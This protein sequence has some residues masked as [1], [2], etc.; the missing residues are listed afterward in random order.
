VRL[1]GPILAALVLLAAC[2]GDR[3]GGPTGDPTAVVQASPDRTVAAGRA[4][5]VVATRAAVGTGTIDFATGKASL[6]VKPAAQTLAEFSDPAVAIEV[7][8]AA[9][10]IV[11]YGGAEVRGASTIKYE[12]DI[13]PSPDLLARLGRP[14]KGDT[15]YAD[16]SIDAQR[17]IRQVAY[18]LDLNEKRPSDTH[19][20]L[21]KLVTVDFYDF[22]TTPKA[23]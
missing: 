17:R 8:R 4:H 1:S 2:G 18:P 7:V 9:V 3:T 15:F 22:P 5:V 10:S 11:P 20:I 23:G 14:L 13:A 19:K 6:K 16:V 12:L 21:A